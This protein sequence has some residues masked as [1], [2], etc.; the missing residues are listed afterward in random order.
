MPHPGPC[1][2][3]PAPAS[4]S[5]CCGTTTPTTR[6]PPH[7]RFHLH[8]QDLLLVSVVYLRMCHANQH[9][10]PFSVSCQLCKSLP[11]RVLLLIYVPSATNMPLRTN[12]PFH[13]KYLANQNALQTTV[14][15]Q[16][17]C[18]CYPMCLCQSMWRCPIKDR[19]GC[20]QAKISRYSSQTQ[21]HLL[22]YD[23][24]ATTDWVNLRQQRFRWLTPRAATAGCSPNLRVSRPTIYPRA[25]GMRMETLPN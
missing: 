23:D 12:V 15:G 25:C 10:L 5:P 6:L 16:T 21:K 13:S 18:L 22:T 2:S 17:M 9:V 3:P 7:D 19:M 11:T 1:R 14:P 4:A 8:F 20:S 24:G